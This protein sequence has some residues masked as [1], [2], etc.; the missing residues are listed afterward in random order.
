MDNFSNVKYFRTR[1]MASGLTAAINYTMFFI[2]I[3][4]YYD[5]ETSI[6]LF[7]VICLYGVIGIFGTI[8]VYIF[9]PETEG[10][11]LEEIEEHFSNNKLK[12]TDR[13]ITSQRLLDNK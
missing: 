13:K 6:S 2:S 12:L 5:L 8:F 3:K 9:L 1:G 10:K 7:G 4:T 11:T